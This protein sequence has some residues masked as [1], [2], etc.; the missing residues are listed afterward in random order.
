MF[1]IVKKVFSRKAGLTINDKGI[2][3]NSNKISIGLIEWDDI[4]GVETIQ[5]NIPVYGYFFSVSS[6]KMLVLK[7]N[8]PEKYI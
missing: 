5:V 4:T 1:F 6:P 2:I 8:E 7:T 3:D